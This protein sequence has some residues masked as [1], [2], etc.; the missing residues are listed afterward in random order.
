MESILPVLEDNHL[1]AVNKPAGLPS[2]PD[3]SGDP[4]LDELVKAYLREKYNKP[5]NIYLALLHRLDRPTSGVVLLAKTEKAAGRMSELFRKREIQ[6]TYCAIVENGDSLPDAGEAEDFLAPTANGGME[7]SSGGGSGGGG[8]KSDK[9]RAA[10]LS[11]RVL[12]R[13]PGNRAHLEIDLQT[14][15]KHQIRV[16][17]AH[18]GSPVVGDFRYGARGRTAHPEPIAGGRAI[19]LHAGKVAF[20][21]PVR[22]EP[23]EIVAPAPEFW[24]KISLEFSEK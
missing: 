4:A 23:V 21:H 7:I 20:I 14:G 2:Q 10:R 22:K 15:V 24:K 6:K 12:S 13:L 8:K 9:P 17:L 18:R 16:Q 19:L 5:G 3:D 11:W 1:L